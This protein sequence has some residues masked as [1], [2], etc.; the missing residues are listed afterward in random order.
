MTATFFSLSPEIR[1]EIYELCLIAPDTVWVNPPPCGRGEGSIFT[2][3]FDGAQCHVAKSAD[4]FFNSAILG[5]SP[6][7]LLVNRRIHTEATTIFYS[8]NAFGFAG[9][10]A[11]QHLNSFLDRIGKS[12]RECLARVDINIPKIK[13]GWVSEYDGSV[14]DM[15]QWWKSKEKQS[16]TRCHHLSAKGLKSALYR[17]ANECPGLWGL[18]LRIGL[19]EKITMQ[20]VVALSEFQLIK[21]L[22][23]VYLELPNLGDKYASI[24]EDALALL[25]GGWGWTEYRDE[26]GPEEKWFLY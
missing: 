5:L 26:A 13:M 18:W 6:A 23:V 16:V 14:V 8:K 1:L 21:S 3:S 19:D 24:T 2:T 7:L 17:L 10:Y 22:R 20:S 15:F 11:Y 4:A 9:K 25:T 12:N